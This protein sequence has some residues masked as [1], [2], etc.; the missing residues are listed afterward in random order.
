M[1]VE[2]WAVGPRFTCAFS[3]CRTRAQVVRLVR[4]D[5]PDAASVGRRGRTR[6]GS[7]PSAAW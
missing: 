6:C 7:N 4:S 3:D 1:L 5:A 2:T